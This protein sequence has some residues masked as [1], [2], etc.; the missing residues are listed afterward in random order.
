MARSPF[1]NEVRT[2]IRVRGMSI[3]TEKTYIYW[4]RFFIRYNN[5]R[6]PREMGAAEI[7]RFLSYLATERNVAVNAQRIDAIA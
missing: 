1:L 2:S 3:R 5:C 7:G 4:I 6:H